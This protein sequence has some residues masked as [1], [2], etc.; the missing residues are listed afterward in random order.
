VGAAPLV[1]GCSTTKTAR[2]SPTSGYAVEASAQARACCQETEQWLAGAEAAAA[3]QSKLGHLPAAG[4]EERPQADGPNWPA[5]GTWRSRVDRRIVHAPEAPST[6][7]DQD[8]QVA[9]PD[10]WIE[11]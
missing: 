9:R 10:P 1:L 4:R 2:R 3:G 7:S 11:T 6:A 5:S 8:H